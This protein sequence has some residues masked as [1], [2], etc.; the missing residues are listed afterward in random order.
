[1]LRGGRVLTE[2][3]TPPRAC[4]QETELTHRLSHSCLIQK[5]NSYDITLSVNEHVFFFADDDFSKKPATDP[6]TSTHRRCATDHVSKHGSQPLLPESTKFHRV[7]VSLVA[8]SDLWTIFSTE[9]LHTCNRASPSCPAMQLFLMAMRP[10]LPQCKS[11]SS[12]RSSRCEE[13]VR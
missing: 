4:V 9:T 12:R 7:Q 3:P 11:L 1:M 10:L 5:E 8:F 13:L 6:S 2:Q